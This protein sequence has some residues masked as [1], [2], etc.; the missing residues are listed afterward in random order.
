MW[1]WW[2]CDTGGDGAIEVDERMQTSASHVYAAGDC[3][4]VKL[5]THDAL[6]RP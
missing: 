6:H 3:A 5:D 1:L 4:A 2:K